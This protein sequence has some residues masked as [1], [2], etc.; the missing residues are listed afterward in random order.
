MS[1]LKKNIIWNFITK[2]ILIF[3][4][5]FITRIIVNQYGAEIY[6]LFSITLVFT[7]YLTILDFGMQI[8]TIKFVSQYKNSSGEKQEIYSS[9]FFAVVITS[10]LITLIGYLFINTMVELLKIPEQMKTD[11]IICFKIVLIAVFCNFF[12]MYFRGIIIAHNYM[13]FSSINNVVVTILKLLLSALL[14]LQ[15]YSIIAIVGIYVLSRV[16]ETTVQFYIVKK[17]IGWKFSTENVNVNRMKEIAPYSAKMFISNLVS[18]STTYLDKL[19]IGFYLPIQYISYYQVPYNLSSKTNIIQSNI[20]PAV[21][22]N[23]VTKNG[24]IGSNVKEL[25]FK[26]NYYIIILLAPI[27]FGLSIFSKEILT[28]WINP[29]FAEN[30]FMVLKIIAPAF[31]FASMSIV[32]INLA[33]ANKM[34]NI[35]LIIHIIY[36]G[37]FLL[38]MSLFVKIYGVIGAAFAFLISNFISWLI[39]SFWINISK[40]LLKEYFLKTFKILIIPILVVLVTISI[41]TFI[42]LYLS[43]IFYLVSSIIIYLNE[44]RKYVK[45]YRI[46][47]NSNI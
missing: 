12:N 8:S 35:I 20:V 24:E 41:K 34:E 37:I 27:C 45:S 1:E 16:I 36:L 11:A 15:G 43:L 46:G 31:L 40:N 29:E 13:R 6:G 47:R 14:A 32:I 22:P 25:Y 30:S 4:S 21:F 18:M 39:F 44:G 2:F 42:A 7:G 17:M 9:I 33:N 19:I 3:F 23:F 10:V 5:F 26:S 38:L 28:L